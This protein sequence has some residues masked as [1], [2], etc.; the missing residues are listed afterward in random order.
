MFAGGR[1][2]YVI[3]CTVTGEVYVGSSQATS[4]RMSQHITHLRRGGHHNSGLQAAWDRY[5][6]SAFRFLTVLT[7]PTLTSD[8]LVSAEAAWMEALTAREP[9]LG[10]NRD[11]A[12]HTNRAG[13][14]F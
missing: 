14:G 10:L 8:E 1:G 11:S 2:I 4:T 12:R 3:V 7:S 6:E 5:G 9:G 13:H